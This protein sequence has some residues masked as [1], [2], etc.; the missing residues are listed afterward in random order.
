MSCSSSLLDPNDSSEL[1]L[2]QEITEGELRAAERENLKWV[3]QLLRSFCKL[4]DCE[5]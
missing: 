5:T 2:G 4:S 1:L 3:S